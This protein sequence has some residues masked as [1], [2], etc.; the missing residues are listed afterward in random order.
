MK[1]KRRAPER[2]PPEKVAAEKTRELMRLLSDDSNADQALRR[3]QALIASEPLMLMVSVSRVT[4]RF[5]F[6]TSVAPGTQ[7]QDIRLL[8]DA[9]RIVQ[10][11][12][13]EELV[14]LAEARG[15][16]QAA[17]QKNKADMGAKG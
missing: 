14:T 9:L 4:G 11:K 5:S 3:A 12:L 10:R 2:R 6:T 1:A 8:E 15:R 17:E 7:E 13:R 16:K